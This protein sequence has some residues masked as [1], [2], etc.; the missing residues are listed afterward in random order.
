MIGRLIMLFTIIRVWFLYRNIAFLAFSLFFLRNVYAETDPEIAVFRSETEQWK[1]SD[2]FEGLMAFLLDKLKEAREPEFLAEL[3]KE[4]GIAYGHE[5]NYENAVEHYL[6]AISFYRQARLPVSFDLGLMYNNLAYAYDV[7]GYSNRSLWNYEKACEIW[8]NVAWDDHQHLSIVLNNLISGYIEYGDAKTAEKYLKIFEQYLS[9]IFDKHKLSEHEIFKRKIALQFDRI[10]YYAF[11]KNEDQVVSDLRV[12]EQM[13]LAKPQWF[14]PDFS[15]QLLSSYELAGYMFKNEKQFTKAMHYY[16][17][18]LMPQ[19]NYFYEMKYQANMAIVFYDSGAWHSALQYTQRSLDFFAKH[20]ISGS[21]F[22]TLTILKAELLERTGEDGKSRQALVNL[23]SEL[24]RREIE[25][26]QLRNL[27][28]SELRGLNSDRYLTIFIKAAQTYHRLYIK[29]EVPKDLD[30]SF[31]IF[32]LAARMFSEYYLKGRYNQALDTIHKQITE[33]LL[34]A[35]IQKFEYGSPSW[36]ELIELLENNQSR[37]Y[38]TRFVQRNEFNLQ[39]SFAAADHQ[40]ALQNFQSG[41]S[42]E[43][44][45]LNTSLNAIIQN[46]PVFNMKAF[47]PLVQTETTVVRYFIGMDYVFAAVLKAG[48]WHM[49]K[50][51]NTPDEIKVMVDFFIKTVQGL[52][53]DYRHIAGELYGILVKSLQL[54]EGERIVF[55]PEAYLAA[56]NFEVLMPQDHIFMLEKYNISYAFSLMELFQQSIDN[57][58]AGMGKKDLIAFAPAYDG[59]KYPMIKNH[60]EESK[61]IAKLYKGKVLTGDEATNKNFESEAPDYRFIHFAMHTEQDVFNYENSSLIFSS[62]DKLHLYELYSMNLPAEMVVLSACNTGVGALEPGLGIMSLSRALTFAGARSLL[63]SVWPIPDRETG[64]IMWEYYSNLKKGMDKDVALAEAKRTFI[65]ANPLKQ[66]PLYWAG[67]VANGNMMA[68]PQDEDKTFYLLAI[69]AITILL[70]PGF[71][72][73]RRHRKVRAIRL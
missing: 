19:T 73:L 35:A 6:K 54:S 61:K 24:L 8:Y 12:L 17:K 31:S 9:E 45:T 27:N 49:F 3:H 58:K 32:H 2:D 20:K 60:I 67:M 48:S 65:S 53:E 18:M 22:Y 42:T 29:S 59:V 50:I 46:P 69:W 14:H 4:L 26:E 10:K 38:W 72:F 40:G 51:N 5:D 52:S 66:H 1:T 11:V 62:G 36:H 21:S 43:Q 39:N 63:Y 64:E 44:T 30:I 71:I 55:I 13:A 28:F 23:F 16:N 15:A 37:Q 7:T 68:V 56:L 34:N 33:G 47:L 41:I 70:I 57:N 25:E